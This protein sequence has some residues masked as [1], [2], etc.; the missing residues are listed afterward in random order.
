MQFPDDA[1]LEAALAPGQVRR[2]ELV[3]MVDWA[4]DGGYADPNS[5]MSQA[6]I[7]ATIDRQLTGNYPA[8]LEVTEGYAAAQ[9]G[10]KLGG[11][12]PDGTPLVRMF[13][14]YSG[15]SAGSVSAINTPCYLDA[16]VITSSGPVAI[17]Q[18]TG[19]V[20]NAVPS[21]AD[22]TVDLLLR[23]AAALLQAPLDVATWAVDAKLRRTTSLAADGQTVVLSWLID[24]VLR[25][26]GWRRG[27]AW[28]PNVVLGWTLNGSALPEVGH[29]GL[30]DS[31]VRGDWSYNGYLD[32]QIPNRTPYGDIDE[33]YKA[34][35][36]GQLA[37][38][39]RALPNWLTRSETLMTSNAHTTARATPTTYGSN[40]SNLLGFSAKVEVDTAQYHVTMPPSEILFHCEELRHDPSVSANNAPSHAYLR[41]H[42]GTGVITLRFIEN[43][44][45]K[46]WEWT[47]TLAPSPTR[48][49][50]LYGV[51]RF[52]STGITPYVFAD[53]VA[54]TLSVVSNPAWPPTAMAYTF[55]T[56]ATNHGRIEMFGPANFAQV[57]YQHNTLIAGLVAPSYTALDEASVDT[58]S[59]RLQWIPKHK[60]KAAWE[61]L[62][63]L[64]SAD[65]GALYVTEHGVPT[66]DSRPTVVTRQDVD[67]PTLRLT[68][69]QIQNL[70][71]QTALESVANV[72][73]WDL[74]TRDSEIS[75][76]ELSTGYDTEGIGPVFAATSPGQFET[77][78]MTV[79][80][81]PLTV[82]SD[83]MQVIVGVLPFEAL[84]MGYVV[85]SGVVFPNA[86]WKDWMQYYTPP[87]FGQ[88]YTP[89]AP[90]SRTDPSTQPVPVSNVG[91]SVLLG[92][93]DYTDVDPSHIRL[94]LTNNSAG[95]VWYSIDDSTP[96][97][98][99]G[100]TLLVAHDNDRQTME[101]T[102][103]IAIYG[104]RPVTLQGGEW[105]QDESTV[106]P[107][108]ASLLNDTGEPHPFFQ[109]LEIPGDP[110]GQLQDVV[111]IDDR[112]VMGGPIFA[113]VVGIKRTLSKREGIHDT[114]TLRTFGAIGGSWV[115]GDP[116]F[117]I[118]GRTTIVS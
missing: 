60:S 11:N 78:A 71:P 114:L 106:T 22:G 91:A 64:A 32:W 1:D 50:N 38:V 79:R 74:V 6:L 5:D 82:S 95:I 40:N 35:P 39:G 104:Y 99:V 63:D 113:S 47:A 4:M 15:L 67:S 81:Q 51:I 29:I 72:L 52:S 13:S 59:L 23:D 27:P 118:M 98:N 90:G 55:A 21:R 34:A 107:L 70:E 10:V 19:V 115:M 62:R 53:G 87:Y 48:W 3:F 12:A 102:G 85:I 58:S 68:L 111:R 16:I 17:R 36:D 37:F 108:A 93:A 80:T 69:S 65:M 116:D 105:L 44:W 92:H 46:T 83:V 8:E 84:A 100:G 43:G 28:H 75:H 42:H 56:S 54:V 96:F 101:D 88:G 89:Y 7:E 57:F 31:Q 86:A 30:M 76:R 103:S 25:R 2:F 45:V 49:I 61:L 26:S 73:V 109:T 97:L 24:N 20:R 112:D 117:S 18:F 110:R 14:P 66:F 41:F 33:V 77:A 9:M 94:T